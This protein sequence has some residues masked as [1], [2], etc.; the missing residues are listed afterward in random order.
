M[1]SIVIKATSRSDVSLMAIVPDK[2]CRMPTLIGPVSLVGV[3][4]AASTGAG[5]ADPDAAAVGAGA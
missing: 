3:A 5:A 4:A 1:F 2:E